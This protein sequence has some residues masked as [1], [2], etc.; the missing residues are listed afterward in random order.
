MMTR[1]QIKIRQSPQEHIVAD[2]AILYQSM[3]GSDFVFIS[4]DGEEFPAHR[5][6]LIAR[7]PAFAAMLRTDCEEKRTGRC[8]P[9]KD[10]DG[11]TLGVLL[12]FLYSGTVQRIGTVARKLLLAAEKYQLE[13]LKSE[14][15]ASLLQNLKSRTAAELLI[16]SDRNGVA[17]LKEGVM[18]LIRKCPRRFIRFGGLQETS[19]YKPALAD[20]VMLSCFPKKKKRAA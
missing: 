6:V 17:E 1:A 19:S 7:C 12:E 14:C 15:A 9:I 16:V 11:Q 5:A 3:E 8:G 18:D 4:S 10:I 20:E 2:L 13:D